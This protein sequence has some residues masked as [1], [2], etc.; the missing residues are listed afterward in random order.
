MH[1]LHGGG[2]RCK[3]PGCVKGARGL[4]GRCQAHGGGTQCRVMGCPKV[5]RERTKLCKDHECPNNE[6]TNSSSSRKKRGAPSE[7]SSSNKK[8]EADQGN[9]TRMCH[10]EGCDE[11]VMD[12]DK[13]YCVI[14]QLFISPPSLP[15]P[16]SM[17]SD[18]IST[19]LV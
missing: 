3:E 19:R 9:T 2:K 18:H 14:H 6:L 11:L 17:K 13:C 8:V 16:K 10:L 1:S 12:H 5:A 7:S 15:P 4:S